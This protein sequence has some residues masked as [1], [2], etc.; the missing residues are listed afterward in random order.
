MPGD[1]IRLGAEPLTLQGN[2]PLRLDG[3]PRL[4]LVTEGRVSVFAVRLDAA[5][6][7]SGTRLH[8]VTAGVGDALPGW[9]QRGTGIGLFA[10]A[11]GVACAIVQPRETLAPGDADRLDTVL[12]AFGLTRAP[13]DVPADALCLEPGG[14]LRFDRARTVVCHRVGWV[15]VDGDADPH[16]LTSRIW[17]TVAA[18]RCAHGL[19]TAQV[20][21]GHGWGP[22]DA[23]CGE[24]LLWLA[25]EIGLTGLEARETIE[26]R[27]DHDGAAV[28]GALRA[29]A[30]IL[31]GLTAID[32]T[33]VPGD[34]AAA[35]VHRVAGHLGI[36]VRPVPDGAAGGNLLTVT[37]RLARGSGF[38]CRAITLPTAWWRRDI[39]SFVGS[40]KENGAPCAVLRRG[41][42]RYEI[43]DGDGSRHAVT[44]DVA[45]RLAPNGV[46]LYCPLPARALKAGDLLETAFR[47][48]GE[49]IVRAMLFTVMA[50]LLGLLVPVVTGVLVDE[51]IPFAETTTI[52]HM[53]L[54]L[55]AV[56]VGSA[57]FSLVRALLLLRFEGRAD[58][59][60]Q[61]AVW[62][63]MLRLP[64]G[65]FRR[66]HTGDL[67]MRALGPT[68]L[69]RVV[70]DTLLSTVLS[71]VFS[72]VS[73]VL[74]LSYDSRLAVAALGVSGVAALL[75]SATAMVQLRF[76]RR[77]AERAAETS[78]AL[79]DTVNA[80]PTVRVNGAE[81][82]LFARWL[83]LF[84]AQRREG[85]RAGMAG[86]VFALLSTLIPLLSTLVFFLVIASAQTPITVGDF[87]AFNAAFGQFLGAALGVVTALTASLDAVPILKRMKPILDAVPESTDDRPEVE[88][89]QG[90]VAVSGVTFRYGDGPAVLEDVSVSAPPGSFVALVGPSGSGK[91]TLFR[92]L[93]GFETAERGCVSYDGRSLTDVDPASVRRHL[94][95]VLQR[96]TLL[97]GSILE[98]IVG[99]APLGIDD[100]WEAARLAGLEDDIRAMPMGM[101][102]LLSDGAATLSGGQRQRL[103]IARAIVRRPRV[104]L[105][106][107]ATSALDNRTQ[108]IVADSLA[109]LNATRIVIAHRLSTVVHADLI[110]VME[111]GR[112]VER[113]TYRDLMAQDGP[114]RAI[115]R[116]QIL[117]HAPP[118]VRAG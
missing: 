46:A 77:L 49:D 93:L 75:L 40:R 82:R 54:G 84:A 55:A 105:L 94:G 30:G 42:R 62:D 116:R 19:S 2:R 97:P 61:A 107:E 34:A 113:G 91:S 59:R 86:A 117:D 3:V 8:V 99:S 33:A 95:V 92:L 35:A 83:R 72:V 38:R 9:P 48:S 76:E 15:L 14:T 24:V 63:R 69:R 4:L 32:G 12:A 21:A 66:F 104:L 109:R 80:L 28:D 20:V 43:V 6:E 108:A 106:D 39:P 57:M 70:A 25:A 112:I 56:A 23:V 11:I 36:P 74:M 31:G 79:I 78:S 110:C 98:N 103:M 102:T 101:H 52:I 26:A 17:H 10:I 7:P 71:A 89:L 60:L 64:A 73:F 13:A 100:A 51:S 47:G 5:G 18:D 27:S 81:D 111:R 90:A 88:A 114:F 16:L 50:V 53:A 118:A 65:F 85:F 45:R 115:A 67:L 44:A 22:V 37:Q 87:V 41:H 29:A 96:G 68:Q 1:V 58:A